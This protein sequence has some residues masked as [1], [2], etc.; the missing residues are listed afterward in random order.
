M[1][2]DDVINSVQR[3]FA[4]VLLEFSKVN[5]RLDVLEA[6]EAKRVQFESV[7]VKR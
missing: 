6:K 3:E 2:S 7:E 5:S 1:V 4:A